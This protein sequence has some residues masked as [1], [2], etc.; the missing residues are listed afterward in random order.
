MEYLDYFD[1][2]YHLLGKAEKVVVHRKGLWHHTF[3]CWVYTSDRKVLFQLRAKHIKSC[4]GLLD[5]TC[6]GHIQA[7]E[8]PLKGGLRELRE[9]LGLKVSG[10]ELLYLGVFQ[11]T[12]DRAYPDGK[13]N[14]NREY[15]HVYL[16]KSDLPLKEYRLQRAELDG[17]FSADLDDLFRLFSKEVKQIPMD[18][19]VFDDRNDLATVSKKMGLSAFNFEFLPEHYKTVFVMIERALAHQ[20]YFGI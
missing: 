2:N 5:V 8:S 7:G 9:E 16:L 11:H 3:H 14:L 12:A 15:G 1:G 17:I 20:K 18:G 4:P 10:K 19:Y 6:G 13:P